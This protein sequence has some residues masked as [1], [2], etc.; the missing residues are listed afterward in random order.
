MTSHVWVLVKRATMLA[1]QRREPGERLR[2]SP[3]DAH[4][5]VSNG[6]AELRNDTDEAAL[7]AAV[8]TADH[9][10]AR[11]SPGFFPAVWRGPQ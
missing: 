11:S 8:Q 3:Q 4:A 6:K 7:R 9:Q 2:L 10:A 5:L 1:G